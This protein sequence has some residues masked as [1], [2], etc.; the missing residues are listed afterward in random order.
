MHAVTLPG[1]QFQEAADK[2][3]TPPHIFQNSGLDSIQFCSVQLKELSMPSQG[4][5]MLTPASLPPSFAHSFGMM[6]RMVLNHLGGT[7]P[8]VHLPGNMASH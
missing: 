5:I 6:G 8:L 1:A 3:R 2:E 7:I 4:V